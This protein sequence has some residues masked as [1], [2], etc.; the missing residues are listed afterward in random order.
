MKTVISQLIRH[1]LFAVHRMREQGLFMGMLKGFYA[2][3]E[4]IHSA[5]RRKDARKRLGGIGSFRAAV[6]AVIVVGRLVRTSRSLS[7]NHTY[8]DHGSTSLLKSVFAAKDKGV[9]KLLRQSCTSNEAMTS[10]ADVELANSLLG[11][12]DTA[13]VLFRCQSA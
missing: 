10:N 3:Y 8:E 7:N 12:E 4:R 11:D 5:I 2:Y 9:Q 13:S 1:V 6:T